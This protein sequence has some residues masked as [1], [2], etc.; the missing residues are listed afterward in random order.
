MELV[1]TFLCFISTLGIVLL[2]NP[3]QKI[4]SLIG[5]LLGLS[6]FF[7]LFNFKFLSLS[8][9]IVYIGAICILFLF[10]IMIT[11][12]TIQPSYKNY[13]I[14]I[15]SLI[16]TLGIT[17]FFRQ[18]FISIYTSI[19]RSWFNI[20]EYGDV[21]GFFNYL[22]IMNP[23]IIIILGIYLFIILVGIYNILETPKN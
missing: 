1:L 4:I 2:N 13:T 14:G 8:Y 10:V 19:N 18:D 12:L 5:L 7:F 22:Y 9:I 11:N 23:E 6:F 15:I 3:I 21:W 17:F 20:K 16:S